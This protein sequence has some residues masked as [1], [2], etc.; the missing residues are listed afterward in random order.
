MKN[1][2]HV[3][4]YLILLQNCHVYEVCDYRRDMDW[5]IGFIDHLYALLGA[6]SNYSATAD[7]HSLQF[8]TAPAKSFSACCVFH[9]RSLVTASNSGDSSAS[10]SQVHLSQAPVQNSCQFP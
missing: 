5:I 1:R 4:I 8:T 10:R 2:K 6:T 7:L 3:N 9:S